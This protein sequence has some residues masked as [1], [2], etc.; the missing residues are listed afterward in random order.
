[1]YVCYFTLLIKSF[2]K[3]LISKV[4]L[5]L[6]KMKIEFKK[7]NIAMRQQFILGLQ[8]YK[9]MEICDLLVFALASVS[10]PMDCVKFVIKII[11]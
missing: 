3:G 9:Y 10:V 11:L 2:K 4:I 5:S 7:H 6:F 1:M 8:K